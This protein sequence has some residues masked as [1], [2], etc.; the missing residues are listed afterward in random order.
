MNVLRRKVTV[1]FLG[2]PVCGA[3]IKVDVDPAT[4]KPHQG[5]KITDNGWIYFYELRPRPEGNSPW[6][7][8]VYRGVHGAEEPADAV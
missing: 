5:R 7:L 3:Q 6:W 2:G 4:G 1:E 8:Y